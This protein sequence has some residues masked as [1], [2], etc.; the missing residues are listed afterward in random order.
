MKAEIKKP[1]HFK[2]LKSILRKP[3]A[4]KDD[5]ELDVIKRNLV[6]STE[7]QECDAAM[8]KP[9]ASTGAGK[10]SKSTPIGLSSEHKQLLTECSLSVILDF[11]MDVSRNVNHNRFWNRLKVVCIDNA[12]HRVAMSIHT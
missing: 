1:K 11:K 4:S 6:A 9:A 2:T 3:V 10:V 8:K 5:L 12:I 7:S